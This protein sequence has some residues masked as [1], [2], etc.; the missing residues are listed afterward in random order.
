MSVGWGNCTVSNGQPSSSIW[1]G[2]RGE[3]LVE[4]WIPDQNFGSPEGWRSVVRR[5]A[6]FLATIEGQIG[7]PLSREW[8]ACSNGQCRNFAA[9]P[10]RDALAVV[11]R[12]PSSLRICVQD[13]SAVP[14]KSSHVV[15]MLSPIYSIGPWRPTLG[16]EVGRPQIFLESFF[17]EESRPFS[18]R[19][20]ISS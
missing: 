9:V 6:M 11:P 20:E 2:I 12:A 1:M 16:K 13:R 14:Q 3:R 18:C 7:N 5:V 15:G 17:L 10:C 8:K 19:W 4:I